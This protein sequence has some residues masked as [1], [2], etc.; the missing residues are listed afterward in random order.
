MEL[1]ELEELLELELLDE[2]ELEEEELLLE[3]DDDDELTKPP[4]L[5]RWSI[6]AIWP[7]VTGSSGW[8]SPSSK[9]LMTPSAY[10]S[11]TAESK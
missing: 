4:R 2:E 1:I 10:S 9:P 6:T 11:P 3:R 7:R 5:K 8:K